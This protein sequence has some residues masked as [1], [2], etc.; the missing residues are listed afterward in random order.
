MA[1]QFSPKEIL[2]TIRIAQMENL[3]IRTITMGI[4]AQLRGLEPRGSGERVLRED[5]PLG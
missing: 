1:I 3:D 2:E 5:L 4:S